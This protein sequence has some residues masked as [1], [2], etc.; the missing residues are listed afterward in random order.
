ME[1]ANPHYLYFLLLLIPLIGWYIYKLRRMQASFKMSSAEPFRG[2]SPGIRTYLRHFPFVLRLAAI[3]LLIIVLAR[4]QSVDSSEISK[5]EGIDIMLALD[6]SGSMLGQDFKPTRLEAAKKVA[7]EF[8]NSRPNDKIGLVV[9]AGESFT[10]CPLTT[11]HRILLNL[12]NE[13]QFGLIEDGT[14]IGMGL[15]NCVNRLKDSD[16]KSRVVIL[17]TDGENNAGQ[18][19]PQTAAET[20]ESYG[21]RVHTI[22][23][24]SKGRI[25]F[26]NPY[27]GRTDY[28]EFSMDTKILEKIAEMTGGEFFEATNNAK[29]KEVYDEIDK[30]EKYNI[31]TNTVTRRKE[32]Y[33]PFA[34][35]ALCVVAFELF[36]RRTMFRTIP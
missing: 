16:S 2:I 8:I 18:I 23:V 32:L 3:T 15:A 10:Q 27:T 29:L 33:F 14:A 22:A 9:F 30:M 13:V 4:P 26:R 24:G 31:S 34:L 12:L 35:A 20:A 11:D 1:Y 19:A 7:A 25:P 17:L 21:I 36:L 6:V 5:T 28:Q